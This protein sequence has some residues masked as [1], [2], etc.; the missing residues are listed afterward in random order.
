MS[1][2][3]VIP[4]GPQH[5]VFPEPIQLRLVLEDEKVIEALPAIGYVHRGLEKLAEQRDFIQDVYI[6][7]RICG[8]CS[9]MHAMNYCQGI[10]TLMD[11]TIPDRA[12]FLRVIWAELHRMHSHLL[13]L[14]LLAD[15]FGFE[16]LFMQCMR[17][18]EDIIDVMEMTAGNRILLTTCCIGGVRKDIPA[19]M[20]GEVHKALDRVFQQLK[21]LRPAFADDYTV[22]K[23]L[24]GVGV[25][26]MEK[27][28]ELGAVGPVA[29]ASGLVMDLR[30]TGYAAYKDLA[31]EPII[32]TAGDCYARMMIRLRELDQSTEL[33][34]KAIKML[35]EGPFNVPVKGN[36]TGEVA[37]RIEQPRGELLFFV[38]GNGTKNLDRFRARTPTFANI[39]PL[40]H[41]L[42]GYQLADVPV[43]VISID[44]C[45]SCTER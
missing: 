44:P 21:D 39:P 19:E 22:K 12:R 30:Q 27:A 33:V 14:G 32:E 13:F 37:A 25:L 6:V 23:R 16:N 43:I 9:F 5:P 8:I 35:P 45:I 36:P 2:R 1:R 40:L 7:E 29:K 20:L 28:M 18:R 26:S 24:I 15:S 10:E 41:M 11:I 31:Y 4:F 3:T 38:K 42:P 17:C 34:H